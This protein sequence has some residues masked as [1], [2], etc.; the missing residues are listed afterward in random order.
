MAATATVPLSGMGADFTMALSGESNQTVSSGQTARYTMILSPLSGS[1]GTFTFQCATL[2][3]HASCAFN[4]ASETVAANSTGSVTIQIATGQSNSA[5]A[6]GGPGEWRVLP[7]ALGVLLLPAAW[8][9][10]RKALLPLV[11]LM[12]AMG[13]TS[14]SGGGGGGGGS[15]P[16]GGGGTTTSPGTYSVLVS[17]SANGI[18]HKVTVSLTVD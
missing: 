11:L 4:P 7:V 3:A 17:A 15:S 9:R 2:P 6:T 10:R 5:A 12:L 14:C 1:S 18:S 16:P 13:F 8:G